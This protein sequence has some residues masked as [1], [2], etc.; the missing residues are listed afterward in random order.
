MKIAQKKLAEEY[1]KLLNQAHQGM[2]RAI[3]IKKKEMLQGIC[4]NN[5]RSLQSG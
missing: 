3:E 1:I 2:K 4:W 5:V